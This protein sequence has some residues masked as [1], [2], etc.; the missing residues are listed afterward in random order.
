M[1]LR[2]GIAKVVPQTDIKMLELFIDNHRI[3]SLSIANRVVN[4]MQE[5]NCYSR[6]CMCSL[7]ASYNSISIA[8]GRYFVSVGTILEHTLLLFSLA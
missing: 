4:S 3:S 2:H 1:S 5:M 7:L 6:E 8:K